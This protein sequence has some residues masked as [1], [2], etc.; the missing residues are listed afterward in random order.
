MV[1]RYIDELNSRLS[2]WE[3]IKR[4]VILDHELTVANGELTPSLKLRRK[5][6]AERYRK[7][8]E[9]LYRS[10]SSPFAADASAGA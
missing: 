3:T 1:K 9:E 6:V 10:T 5:V 4:F 2:H 8:L 7:E